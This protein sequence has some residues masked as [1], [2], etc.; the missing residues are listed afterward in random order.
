MQSSEMK[1]QDLSNPFHHAVGRGYYSSYYEPS[2]LLRRKQNSH[3]NYSNYYSPHQLQNTQNRTHL[4]LRY[5]LLL[6]LIFDHLKTNCR[7]KFPFYTTSVKLL[8]SVNSI[9]FVSLS[10]QLFMC[11]VLCCL[12]PVTQNK[13]ETFYS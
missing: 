10:P 7:S 1:V 13:G 6:M 11:L 3:S 5:Y 2:A 8:G 9:I 12:S 4:T